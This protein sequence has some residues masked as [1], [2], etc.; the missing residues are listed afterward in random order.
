M[1]PQRSHDAGLICTGTASLT[2]P[3]IWRWMAR[4]RHERARNHTPV[5]SHLLTRRVN[6]RILGAL[7]FSRLFAP[8]AGSNH[9]CTFN[10]TRQA[11]LRKS[12]KSADQTNRS[13]NSDG[14]PAKG[15]I[16]HIA[17]RSAEPAT[18]TSSQPLRYS[19]LRNFAASG[20]PGQSSF[21]A[22]QWIFFPTR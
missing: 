10:V 13:D 1:R 15:A 2:H 9:A 6:T 17:V 21:A 5:K 8:F 14:T 22:S 4:E 19:R 18:Y 3:K 16:S 11:H 7:L 12:V 20:V